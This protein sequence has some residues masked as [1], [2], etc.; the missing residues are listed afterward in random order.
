MQTDHDA[1]QVSITCTSV[2]NYSTPTPKCTLMAWCFGTGK[3]V[4]KNKIEW[5]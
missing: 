5:D 4:F 1:D 3:E 2:N